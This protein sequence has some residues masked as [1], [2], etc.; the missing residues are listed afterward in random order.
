MATVVSKRKR[1]AGRD[2]TE[3]PAKRASK[4]TGA[5]TGLTAERIRDEALKLID[6]EGLES[7][8][9]RR[10]GAALGCEAMAI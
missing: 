5:G 4:R 10:L 8:S 2:T 6:A 7:F 3:R 1:P 9:T